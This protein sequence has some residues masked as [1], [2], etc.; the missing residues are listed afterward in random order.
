MTAVF[1]CG[2]LCHRPL[3]AVILGAEA[4]LSPATAADRAGRLVDAPGAFALCPQRGREVDGVVLE[5]ATPEALARLAF[6][7]R[8]LGLVPHRLRVT[9]AHGRGPGI[10]YALRAAPA[11]GQAWDAALWLADHAELTVE[12][13][14]EVMAA[15]GALSAARL[16]ARLGS[17]R[18]RAASRMRARTDAA[19]HSLRRAP[20]TIDVQARR[21]PYAHFF[22][23]EEYDL[24]FRRFDGSMSPVVTRAAFISTDAVTVLPY[25]AARDRVLLVE[26]VRMAPFVR[27]DRNPWQLE[28]IAGRI[29]PGETPEEAARREAVEESGLTLGAL[30]PVANYYPS[31][32][33]KTEFLYSY[34]ALTDLPDDAAGVFGVEHE[35]ENIRGHLVSFD[36]AM[37]LIATGEIGSGPLVLTLLWLQGAR[38]GLRAQV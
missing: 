34:L 11:E 16:H 19:P 13:A 14:V 9:S 1:L 33:A 10:G 37:A 5:G 26:Q 35:A 28:T 21:Q 3:L 20:G 12:T 31:P 17:I 36:E 18:V 27:G 8:A 7:A 15:Y 38:A 22:A 30:L 29:D 6:Y 32:G 25:D 4:A 2:P 24:S 23:V